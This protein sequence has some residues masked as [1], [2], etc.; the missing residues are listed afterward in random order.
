MGPHRLTSPE[1]TLIIRSIIG[2]WAS[3]F[4]FGLHVKKST[5]K[6]F[7][8]IVYFLRKSPITLSTWIL[9]C[10]MPLVFSSSTG[11]N[12]S[13][14]LVNAGIN[15]VTIPQRSC[16]SRMEMLSTNSIAVQNH[17]GL[18][19]R[20]IIVVARYSILQLLSLDLSQQMELDI[21]GFPYLDQSFWNSQQS[22]TW[23]F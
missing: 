18:L 1:Q 6:V 12:C 7:S 3:G 11:F 5:G 21:I 10:A 14:S 22:G 20:S 2:A 9:T 17:R 13:F 8:R 16:S 19:Q 4:P 23:A 15:I